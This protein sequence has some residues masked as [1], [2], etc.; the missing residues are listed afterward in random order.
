ILPLP[1]LAFPLE[2]WYNESVL[3]HSMSTNT[4]MTFAELAATLG[5]RSDT[6]RKS[7]YRH[8]WSIHRPED[9]QQFL[10]TRFSDQKTYPKRPYQ[11]GAHLQKWQF[12]RIKETENSEE[13]RERA[14]PFRETGQ[15][16]AKIQILE[17]KLAAEERKKAAVERRTIAENL[18]YRQAGLELQKIWEG[19]LAEKE[20]VLAAK[21]RKIAT[22]TR[23]NEK[24]AREQKPLF[25]EA[26]KI[27]V[28]QPE[29][30]PPAKG[31]DPTPQRRVGGSASKQQE[32]LNSVPSSPDP[33]TPSSYRFSASLG[34]HKGKKW[35]TP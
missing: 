15:M 25:R 4:K 29:H 27:E 30:S 9:V 17:A 3:T 18:A 19:K 28:E 20:A 5:V 16:E 14:C 22:L 31:G 32:S 26:E 2:L 1:S 23:Q 6:L 11:T 8:K 21:E 13:G 7:F 12:R 35:C 34:L 24:E 10:K 33:S